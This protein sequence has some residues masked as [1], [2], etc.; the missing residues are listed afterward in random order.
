LMVAFI[1]SFR[2]TRELLAPAFDSVNN[3]FRKSSERPTRPTSAAGLGCSPNCMLPQFGR[4]NRCRRTPHQPSTVRALPIHHSPPFRGFRSG[5]TPLSFPNRRATGIRRSP[6][7]RRFAIRAAPTANKTLHD[8]CLPRWA[9]LAMRSM[10]VRQSWR[11][12]DVH[13]W[14]GAGLLKTESNPNHRRY[15]AGK[16]FALPAGAGWLACL[17]PR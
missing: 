2:L 17:A 5:R 3:Y 7:F 11:E 10:L 4:C 9:S 16:H 6:R 1:G 15:P 13:G 12:L 8:Q 14:K